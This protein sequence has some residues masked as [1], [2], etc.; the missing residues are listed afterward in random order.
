MKIGFTYNLR[1]KE[2]PTENSPADFYGEFESQE[3]IAAISSGMTQ[4]G[5]EVVHIGDL[6][7]LL[8]FLTAGERVE[9]VFNMSEGRFGRARESQIPG[10]LEAYRIPYTFSDPHTLA[11]CLDKGLT[12]DI[13]QKAGIPTPAYQVL[14]PNQPINLSG[15]RDAAPYFLK[16]LYEGTSKGIDA[17][18]I[19]QSQAEVQERANWLWQNYHQPVLLEKYLSGREFTVGI[20]GTGEQARAIGTLEISL[21]QKRKVYGFYEKEA[22]EELVSYDPFTEQPL[23]DELHQIALKTWRTLECRDGGRVDFKLDENGKPFVLE[24]NTLPGMHPTHS[25]LPMIAT[26]AGMSFEDLLDEILQ[27]AMRRMDKKQSTD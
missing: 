21:K 27:S 1:D 10:V 14:H 18:A 8:H 23:L 15:V 19:V 25:D 11:I 7:S 22:C 4:L 13:L 16:P 3:T 17:G 20:V 5:H 26:N 24:A 6:P 9:M 2:T 12:K